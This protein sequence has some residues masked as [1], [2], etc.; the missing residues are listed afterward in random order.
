MYFLVKCKSF[1]VKQL[2][3]TRNLNKIA[4]FLLII[5]KKTKKAGAKLKHMLFHPRNQS[6]F[7]Y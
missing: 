4:K 1:L 6:D 5:F 7:C 3:F 2:F